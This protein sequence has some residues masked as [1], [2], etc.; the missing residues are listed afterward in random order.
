MKIIATAIVSAL[1]SSS[2]A[3]T[4]VTT[5]TTA[6]ACDAAA[7]AALPKYTYQ[8]KRSFE[9]AG[10]QGIAA[11]GAFYYVSG[12][13]DLFKYNKDG[14]LLASNPKPFDGY[15][16]AANHIGDIDVYKNELYISSEWFADG[17]GKDIQIAVHDADTMK[18]KRT[19]PFNA[20][21]GQQEVSSMAV[22][23]KRNS[24]WM[25]SWVGE[26][27]GR[28]LYEYDLSSG[29]YKRKVH[30]QAVPQWIQGIVVH[31]GEIYLT[32]DDGTADAKEFDHLYRVKIED[33]KP[34]AAVVLEKTFSDFK[35]FGEIE[36]LTI[37]RQT[38]EMLVHAN[39]GKK[40]V[41]GMPKGFYPGYEREISD[42]YVYKMTPRCPAK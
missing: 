27:S 22:D 17:A 35:D 18:L 10:R 9:V 40:I 32:A 12:S 31:E 2:A 7:R 37:D 36:G 28:Y 23:A 20:E 38:G 39:R 15:Q 1:L 26:E 33:G 16:V 42:V 4:T 25:A 3:A 11:D 29:A 19:F 30:L 5:V 24:V 41:L 14:K 34:N 6:A 13:V 8:L 21:S